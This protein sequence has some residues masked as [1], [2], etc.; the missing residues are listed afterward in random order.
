MRVFGGALKISPSDSMSWRCPLVEIRGAFALDEVG[1]VFGLSL[2]VSLSGPDLL[3]GAEV[4]FALSVFVRFCG[5]ALLVEGEASGKSDIAVALRLLLVRVVLEDMISI[6]GI[7][8]S[9]MVR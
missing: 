7:Y 2:L 5:R 4:G 1:V 3:E 9:Q 6:Q 8:M